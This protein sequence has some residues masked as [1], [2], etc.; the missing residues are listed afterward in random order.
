MFVSLSVDDPAPLADCRFHR[1]SDFLPVFSCISRLTCE[2]HNADNLSVGDCTHLEEAESFLVALKLELLVLLQ[3]VRAEM[4]SSEIKPNEL[5]YTA[6]E[7]QNT[8][9]ARA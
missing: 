3:G 7:Q 2:T 1:K 9:P 4:R 5:S 6:T 8:S